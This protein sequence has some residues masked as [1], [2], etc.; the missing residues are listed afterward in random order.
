VI[1]NIA[2]YEVL[3]SSKAST[4]VPLTALYPLVTVILAVI[5]LRE[6]L[7]RIQLAGI[8][9]SL[10]AI[11]FFNVQAEAGFF[12]PW[13]FAAL[14]PILFWGI[15][16][17]V[18]K[19]A[20][21]RISGELATV[22]FLFAFLAAIPLIGLAAAVHNAHYHPPPPV[23]SALTARAIMLVLLLGLTLA[24]GNYACLLA[25]AREGKAS[26]IAPLS[27]L[28]PVVSLPIAILFFGERPSLRESVGIALALLAVVAIS[29]ESKAPV[30]ESSTT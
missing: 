24:L 1:G 5:F 8:L 19:L 2:Y 18:Q 17:F 28:Y 20:T 13:L 7:N 27:S 21:L 11:Y 6:R 12:S 9:I 16:G 4:V 3:G 29:I 25:Y 30:P 26:I 23:R 14:V 15:A 22:Y 10:V